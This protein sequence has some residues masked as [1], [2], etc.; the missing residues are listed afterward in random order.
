MGTFTYQGKNYEVDEKGFLLTTD[1]WDEKFAEGMAPQLNI[2]Q[3]LTKEHWDV[4]RSIVEAFKTT[5]ICPTVYETCR[6]NGLR[7]QDL[8]RLFPTGY[9]RGACKLAGMS[10]EV[11]RVGAALHPASVPGT[12]DF[13]SVY[14]KAYKVDVRGFLI[15][16]EEW[17]EQY[18]VYRAVDMKIGKLTDRHWDIIRYLRKT[19]KETNRIPTIYDTCEANGIELE[20]MERLFPDGYHRGAVKIA[21]IRNE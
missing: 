4:I 8:R 14:G 19:Y 18:A 10:S 5:G 1:P 16:P 13:M 20:E 3:G 11:G 7:F 17:D 12:M 21:G 15:D 2:K 6:T 9:L